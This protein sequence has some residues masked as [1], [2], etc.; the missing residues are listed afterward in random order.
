MMS[1]CG[2]TH[3]STLHCLI[4]QYLSEHPDV[5]LRCPNSTKCDNILDCRQCKRIGETEIKEQ[6]KHG[7]TMIS[8]CDTCNEMYC[9]TCSDQLGK[10]VKV[11]I[12]DSCTENI[13]SGGTGSNKRQHVNRLLELCTLK[14]PHCKQAFYDFSGCCA[15]QCECKKYFCGLCMQ[16][17]TDS[18]ACHSHVS[19]N[20]QL[21]RNKGDYFSSQEQIQ[22]AHRLL[23]IRALKEA[24]KTIPSELKEIVLALLEKDLLDFNIAIFDIR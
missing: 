16:A 9:I 1:V 5:A 23:R 18:G 15:V 13:A 19:N 22:A 3:I 24:V 21:N 2:R 6:E 20:C 7:G 4:N 12:G 8:Y 17:C 10:E 11:H 14:C